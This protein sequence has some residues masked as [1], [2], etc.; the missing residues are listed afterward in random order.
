MDMG[1]EMSEHTKEPWLVKHDE[2]CFRS[3]EDDQS[4]GMAIPIAQIFGDNLEANASRIVACVNACAG[5]A[6]ENLENI[7]MTGETL[8]Q[9]IDVLRYEANV[10]C[11]IEQQRDELLAALKEM[12]AAL[13]VSVSGDDEVAAMVRYGEAEKAARAAIAKVEAA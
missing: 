2:V 4:F 10:A 7:L 8:L 3:Q 11:K 13:D 12:L 5:I 6:T 1:A 9:R